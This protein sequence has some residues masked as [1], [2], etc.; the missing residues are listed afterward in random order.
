MDIIRGTDYHT[1]GDVGYHFMIGEDGT[2][3]QGRPLDFVGAHVL[4]QNDGNIG[5][6]FLGDYGNRPL[7]SAQVSSARALSRMLADV[8]GIERYATHAD[9]SDEKRNELRG[10]AAQIPEIAAGLRAPKPIGF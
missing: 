6:A 8:Y 5:L 4:D 10:A 3:Y 7:T 9:L 1:F 2:I